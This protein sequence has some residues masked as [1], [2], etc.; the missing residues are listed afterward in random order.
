MK[1]DKRKSTAKGKAR[2][3]VLVQ[4][5]PGAAAL[6]AL[7]E[8]HFPTHKATSTAGVYAAKCQA[9][10]DGKA[11]LTLS[12][13]DAGAGH[14][15]LLLHCHAGCEWEALL[16]AHGLTDAAALTFP[17]TGIASAAPPKNGAAKGATV[18]PIH[19]PELSARA[20]KAH[21][22]LMGERPF[23]KVPTAL[24][25]LTK[26]RRIPA[27]LVER[28]LLGLER[29]ALVFPYIRRGA[30][31]WLKFRARAEKKFWRT[32]GGADFLYGVD[33]LVAGKDAILTEGE[34]DKLSVD[35][36]G[37]PCP[38]VSLPNGTETATA[39]VLAPLRDCARVFLSTDTDEPGEKAALQAAR[40]LGPER[41]YRLTFPKYKD[42]NDALQAFGLVKFKR[43]LAKR[44]K[45]AKPMTVATTAEE[46]EEPA[47]ASHPDC[48]K[49]VTFAEVVAAWTGTWGWQLSRPFNGP[50]EYDLL[51]HQPTFGR[52]PANVDDAVAAM[53]VE[54]G[55]RGH[56]FTDAD[57]HKALMAVARRATFH[58]VA[59]RLKALPAWD[60]VTDFLELLATETLHLPVEDTLSRA[61]L[62]R[63]FIGAVA[64]AMEPG[65]KLDTVCILVGDQGAL[66]ST[67]FELA[68]GGP[69]FFSD[70]AVDLK[71][72]DGLMQ[73]QAVWFYE[74]SE[75]E[76]KRRSDESAAKAFLSAR[77]DK[78]R[79]PYGRTV[80][81]HRRGCIIVGTTN[82]DRFLTDPTG[83]RRYWPIT[84]PKGKRLGLGWF[85]KHWGEVWAQALDLYRKG[86]PW[87]LDAGSTLD[88]LLVER[89]HTDN[90]VVDDLEER[91]L[92][93]AAN[94]STWSSGSGCSLTE[95]LSTTAVADLAAKGLGLLEL[96]KLDATRGGTTD[97][98]LAGAFDGNTNYIG[99]HG[100]HDRVRHILELAGW[101]RKRW[102]LHPL[103]EDEP[104]ARWRHKDWPAGK[105]GNPTFRKSLG[106]GF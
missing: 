73:V 104:S 40:V 68:A 61:L 46:G 66:K 25:Y 13:A 87:W 57:T 65:C 4:P 21:A 41:C 62:R 1:A 3:G 18:T 80:E 70:T 51:K 63:T 54:A 94:P 69:E 79:A 91:V 71:H 30:V 99:K 76:T 50:L 86:E 56:K 82:A 95:R 100:L 33:E 97:Q 84:L 14:Q 59:E 17:I 36:A 64:R 92:A 88:K 12:L 37:A 101:T 90:R 22:A 27:A 16:E 11:S 77:V 8:E 55:E 42:A 83:A 2:R 34:P 58:P 20:A 103:L 23:G 48:P 45:A 10:A 78:F 75:L 72:K 98:I 5:A 93:A 44:L 32:K 102:T 49:K 53:R 81:E 60:G 19:A 89:Q 38:A 74:W 106:A 15:R 31:E 24:D 29:G 105:R 85:R 35:A 28:H 9:H 96:A 47:A 39:E 67:F 6:E 43:L 26:K 52:V 7:L